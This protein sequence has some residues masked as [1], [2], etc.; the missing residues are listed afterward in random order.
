MDPSRY[1]QQAIKELRRAKPEHGVRGQQKIV[2]LAYFAEVNPSEQDFSSQLKLLADSAERTGRTSLA[3]AAQSV[4]DDWQSRT[5]PTSNA[6][7]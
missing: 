2:V 4:L 6:S 5:V 1:C 3:R 7:S